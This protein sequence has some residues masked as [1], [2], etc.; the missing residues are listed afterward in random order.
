MDEEERILMDIRAELAKSKAEYDARVKIVVTLM[1]A[2][3]SLAEH[4]EKIENIMRERDARIA[5]LERQQHTP[6]H[7]G[8]VRHGM[9]GGA[10][11][12]EQSTLTDERRGP[13]G[14][15]PQVWGASRTREYGRGHT[16]G[17]YV[18]FGVLCHGQY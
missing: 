13:F 2:L 17:E 8:R 11:G 18:E 16:V 1:D 6:A 12:R 7:Q 15:D 5:R 14:A 3:H 4:C 10:G 9:A